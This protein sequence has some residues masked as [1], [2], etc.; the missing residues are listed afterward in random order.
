[1][2]VLYTVQLRKDNMVQLRKR[3]WYCS[4]TTAGVNAYAYVHAARMR[5]S[6]TTARKM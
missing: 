3:I 5:F 1:M 6:S 2:G 4:S